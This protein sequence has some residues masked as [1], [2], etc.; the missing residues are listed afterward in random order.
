VPGTGHYPWAEN[1]GR[2]YQTTG[3]LARRAEDLWPLL[4]LLAGPDGVD[5]G[6]AEMPLGDPATVDLSRLSVV[7]IEDNEVV[8]VSAE[9]RQA[10]RRAGS[11][12]ASR[13]ARVRPARLEKLKHSLYIWTSMLAA[14]SQTS[15]STLLG[16]GQPIRA[17]RQILRWMLGRSPHTLPALG[18]A[19]LEKLPVL[20][21]GG[22]RRFVELGLALKEELIALIGPEGVLLYPPYASPAPRHN[23]P[24]WPPFNWVYT[25]ILN[26]L[27]LPV[28]QVPLGLNHRGL[29]LGVQVAAQPGHDHLTVAVALALEQGFGG[30]VPPSRFG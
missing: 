11:Y 24:L 17:G 8:P 13:G 9:L 20:M 21:P 16:N 6:C 23:K 7:T 26:V 2:R 29:P 3:P 18:L 4:R 22:V 19:V 10:L 14:S 25:A 12:L 1:Q 5:D 28:T 30:W 27:E 15:F